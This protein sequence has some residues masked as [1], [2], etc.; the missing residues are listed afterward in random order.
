MCGSSLSDPSRITGRDSRRGSGRQLG[1]DQDAPRKPQRMAEQPGSEPEDAPSSCPGIRSHRYSQAPDRSGRDINLKDKDRATPLH[2]AAYLGNLE[3]VD[4]LLQKGATSINDG[5][6]RGQ[7]PLHLACEKGHPKVVTRHFDA[8]ADIEARDLLGRT[9]L[10]VTSMSKNM[11]VGGSLSDERPT[12]TPA[13][14]AVPQLTRYSLYLPCMV[15][16]TW[17]T[18]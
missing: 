18:F 17:L 9:P 11:E 6:Y 4:L 3:I 2:N 5:N 13:S 12:S 15:S 7:K 16:R 14:S 10:M 1:E 8:G